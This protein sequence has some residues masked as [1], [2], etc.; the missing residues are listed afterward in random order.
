MNEKRAPENEPTTMDE[1]IAHLKSA[2]HAVVFTGAGVSTLSGIRDFRGRNGIYKEFD[3]DRIFALDYFLTDPSYYYRH[4]RDFIYNLHTREPSLVHRECARLE[5]AGIVRCVITQNIDMLHQK[6]GSRRVIEL[7]GSPTRHS[8]LKC[9][10]EYSY[11]WAAEIVQKGETP[12]CEGC[13]GIVKP[14][15]VFFGEMLDRRS[16]D[17]AVSESE[18]ADLMLVLGSSLVVQPAASLPMCTL[19]AGGKLAIVN[20]GETP[21]DELATFKFSDLEACFRRIAEAV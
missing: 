13:G 2:R 1:L 6:A 10:R 16:V 21:L 8:C 9:G 19:R 18:Q 4:A 5:Q 20:D 17:E 11:E 7:H 12:R 14:D 3:A 15:I